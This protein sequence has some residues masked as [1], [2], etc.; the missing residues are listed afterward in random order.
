MRK[1][2]QAILEEPQEI[3]KKKISSKTIARLM[4]ETTHWHM[5]P[6]CAHVPI[7]VHDTSA[8]RKHNAASS[9]A[10]AHSDVTCSRRATAA[11]AAPGAPGAPAAPT[12]SIPE[13]IFKVS[14][15]APGSLATPH[16]AASEAWCDIAKRRQ[17]VFLD[18]TMKMDHRTQ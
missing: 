7:T 15:D 16:G 10:V 9:S 1:I 6:T 18:A 14:V 17:K 4:R 3:F 12:K 11:A 8:L 2:R 5:R 13:N